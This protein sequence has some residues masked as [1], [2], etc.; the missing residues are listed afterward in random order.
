MKSIIK[1][2]R[3]KFDG[4]S[5]E[6]LVESIGERLHDEASSRSKMIN[7]LAEMKERLAT[8]PQHKSNPSSL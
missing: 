7:E 8:R 3:E 2:L 5:K 1:E 4:G 6:P